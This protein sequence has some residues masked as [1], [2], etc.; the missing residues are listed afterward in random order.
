MQTRFGTDNYI[1][2]RED[3]S[4]WNTKTLLLKWGVYSC[5][6]VHYSCGL[7]QP[8]IRLSPKNS[9]SL[10]RVL[11]RQS[12]VW[13]FTAFRHFNTWDYNT[14]VV[15]NQMHSVFKSQFTIF[16]LCLQFIRSYLDLTTNQRLFLFCFGIKF[17]PVCMHA[18]T[19]KL[20]FCI[21]SES[22]Q[23]LLNFYVPEI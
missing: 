15:Y 22:S 20:D 2:S 18:F 17:K 5:R 8:D 23:K 4:Y 10:V 14:R 7:V 6:P 21:I 13:L 12:S 3:K 9:D 1:F 11:R 19:F 16:L